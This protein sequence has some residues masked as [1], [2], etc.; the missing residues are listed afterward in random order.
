MRLVRLTVLILMAAPWVNAS[1]RT[2]AAKAPP[3]LV[4][5]ANAYA[6]HY[7]VPPPLV[8]A[9]IDQESGWKTNAISDKGAMGLMQLMPGT[10]R[11]YG[12]KRPFSATDNISG[13]VRYLA[14]LINEFRDLRLVV[15]AYYAGSHHLEKRGLRYSNAEVTAYVKSVRRLYEEELAR[16]QHRQE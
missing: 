10:A 8:R 14:A 7:G 12:V 4:Y 9:I 2:T 1:A 15:A 6:Y 11:E 5:Y 3:A 13:G 16:E